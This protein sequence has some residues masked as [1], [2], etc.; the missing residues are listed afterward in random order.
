[1]LLSDIGMPGEDGYFLIRQIRSR[2]ASDGG[3]LP[4]I[5]ITAF[6]R[7]EDRRRVLDA[8][9]QAHVSKPFE[10]ADLVALVGRLTR[11]RLISSARGS[12]GMPR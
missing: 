8:G 10:P 3:S 11:A 12:S 1:M 2:D 9:F 6:A 7:G 5:A 4:A